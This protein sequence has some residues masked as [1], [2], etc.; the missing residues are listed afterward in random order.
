ML[1]SITVLRLSEFFNGYSNGDFYKRSFDVPKD[2]NYGASGEDRIHYSDVI[3]VEG[4]AW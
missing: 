2:R 3:N 1:P 4:K